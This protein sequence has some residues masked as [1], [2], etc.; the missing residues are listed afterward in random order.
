MRSEGYANTYPSLNNSMSWNR[1]LPTPPPIP[2]RRP[3]IL[4]RRRGRRRWLNCP[5]R[6]LLSQGNR[7]HLI[8]PLNRLDLKIPLNVVRNLNKILLVLIRNQNSLDPPSMSRQ[9]LLLQAADRKHFTTQRNLTRHSNIRPHR[10]LRECRHQRRA[11][12][13]T[14]ARSVF[15]SRAFWNVQMDVELLVE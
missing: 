12:T 3:L 5:H 9:E 4:S 10:N 2:P 14:G 11:H 7:Q 1:L 13:D 6:R 15:R 8:N